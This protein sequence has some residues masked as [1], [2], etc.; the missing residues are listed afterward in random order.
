VQ[1]SYNFNSGQFQVMCTVGF[2]FCF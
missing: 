2:D 1:G